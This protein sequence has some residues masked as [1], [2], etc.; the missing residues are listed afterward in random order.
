[1]EA[2]NTLD[3]VFIDELSRLPK[4]DLVKYILELKILNGILTDAVKEYVNNKTDATVTTN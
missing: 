1:V 2:V 4:G 3:Q